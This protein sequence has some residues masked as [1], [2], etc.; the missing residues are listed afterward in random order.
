MWKKKFNVLL[1]AVATIFLL[2]GCGQSE[3]IT[4]YAQG[5]AML[6]QYMEENGLLNGMEHNIFELKRMEKGKATII[7]NRNIIDIGDGNED[8]VDITYKYSDGQIKNVKIKKTYNEK[9]GFAN[10]PIDE[11]ALYAKKM[12]N[13]TIMTIK[14]PEVY[15]ETQEEFVEPEVNNEYDFQRML[16]AKIDYI[17]NGN[18]M[19]TIAN[20]LEGFNLFGLKN[21]ASNGGDYKKYLKTITFGKYQG[22]NIEWLVIGCSGNEKEI[23]V[24]SKKILDVKC[25][26]NSDDNKW[27]NS[28][29]RNWLNNDFYNE[30]FSSEEKKSIIDTNYSTKKNNFSDK[31]SIYNVSRA[32]SEQGGI[33]VLNIE[34]FEEEYFTP[35]SYA[36]NVSNMG[37][38]L[39]KPYPKFWTFDNGKAGKATF[40]GISKGHYI[41]TGASSNAMDKNVGV[42]P[43][44]TIKID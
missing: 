29:L 35:T 32:S 40:D 11:E 7:V 16:D 24:M 4:D 38:K 26:S 34:A 37:T 27:D 5:E 33:D 28:Y 41:T 43:V 6:K 12:E 23:R 9:F 36:S 14:E 18:K 30:A 44:I 19:N 15:M 39:Y 3:E 10:D 20:Q 1:L 25:F 17:N 13:E 2:A 22:E 8:F 31:V 21:I 42:V